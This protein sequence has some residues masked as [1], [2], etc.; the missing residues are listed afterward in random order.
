MISFKISISAVLILI[1][2]LVF[3]QTSHKVIFFYKP[4]TDSIETNLFLDTLFK[5][6]Y[7][8][9]YENIKNA[10]VVKDVETAI[11]NNDFRFIG[12]SGNSYLY[13]GLEGG[14]ETNRDGTKTFIGLDQKYK[15]NI[16]KYSF[17]VIKETGDSINSDN[18]P[19][20]GIAYEY[21]RKYNLLI[22]E[23]ME[24]IK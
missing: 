17:K 7:K 14:Y 5:F 13:P 19:L 23:K 18:P 3:G 9:Q 6:D 15:S 8:T 16:K 11:R 22:L 24:Q 2:A 20:Q 10:D 12:I 4:Y 1:S 21:A